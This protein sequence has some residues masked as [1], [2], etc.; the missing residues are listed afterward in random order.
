MGETLRILT[1]PGLGDAHWVVLKL[2]ALKQKLGAERLHVGLWQADAKP[3]TLGY[4][5]RLPFVDSC[6]DFNERHTFDRETWERAVL[7]PGDEVQEGI[8]GYDYV[9][10]FNGSLRNGRD[11][12]TEILP[13]LECDWSY[14][15]ESRAEDIEWF[16]S[17]VR[18]WDATRYV[19]AYFNDIGMYKA[20]WLNHFGVEHIAESLLM[21]HLAFDR[22]RIL[23]SGV[24][25]DAPFAARLCEHLGRP[26][27]LIDATQQTDMGQ[28]FELIRN[29]TV[30]VGWCA[31]NTIMSTHFGTPTVMLWSDYFSRKFATCWADKTKVGSSYQPLFV[32]EIQAAR[33]WSAAIDAVEKSH[34]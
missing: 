12:E 5:Q 26:S 4:L 21:L 3:R 33:V 11:I 31:G 18:E 10:S 25:W 16:Y 7:H 24:S 23:L 30:F 8:A 1:M 20:K 6:E 17:K 19:L 9:V 32:E 15:V 13:D 29:A 27:W 2:Q 34:A 14:P 28:L 22:S